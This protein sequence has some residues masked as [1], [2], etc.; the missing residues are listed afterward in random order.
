[1]SRFNSLQK[2]FE[3]PANCTNLYVMRPETGGTGS[4]TSTQGNIDNY[5]IRV[6]NKDVSDRPIG[7]RSTNGR[8]AAPDPLHLQKLSVTL[9]NSNLPVKNLT[10][11]GLDIDR[12]EAWQANNKVTDKF[13]IG[14]VLPLTNS[15]KHVQINIE[16][17]S[18][19][20]QRLAL[21]KEVVKTI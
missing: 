1:M 11:R 4:L 13:M 19:G 8:N 5:R 6:D 16:S 17:S 20:P 9:Q 15:P 12:N 21:F 2:M 14:Q 18:A 7:L 10:E 3:C